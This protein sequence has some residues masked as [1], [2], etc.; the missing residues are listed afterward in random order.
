MPAE[1]HP[2]NGFVALLKNR[3]FLCIWLAQVTSQIAQ[4]MINYLVI[5]LVEDLT[6]SS[7]QTGL[8]I[9]SFLIPGVFFA[10]V[11]G[12]VVD[13]CN[14]R[15]LLIV[16]TL[17][18]AVAAATYFI[19]VL[20]HKWPVAYL[21]LFIDVVT[22]LRN[23]VNQFFWPA[24]SSAIPQLVEREQF[25]TVN[26][27]IGTSTNINRVLGFVLLGPFLLK[28]VGIRI[29][30]WIIIGL[31]LVAAAFLWLIPR[32]ACASVNHNNGLGLRRGQ[33]IL[34][35]AIQ[36]LRT[37]R[38]ELRESWALI[39]R[40]RPMTV[41]IAYSS[42]A[43]ALSL[44]I[45]T[46]APGFVTR[47]LGLGSE[48]SVV[49]ILPAGLGMMAGLF[50]VGILSRWLGRQRLVDRSML[51]TGLILLALASIPVLQKYTN[52]PP[53]AALDLGHPIILV[54][55]TLCFL[56]GMVDS[57]IF[58][59]TQ[60]LLQDRA[61]EEAYGRVFANRQLI[62]NVA[63]MGP[64]LLTGAMGDLVGIPRVLA[65]VGGIT[66]TI[67]ILGILYLRP[68]KQRVEEHETP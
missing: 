33:R 15:T 7:T 1:S 42:V 62:Q 27:L 18:R 67:A 16:T 31:Y 10:S 54:S 52:L 29:V 68:P 4:N 17:L 6:G 22:F 14:R 65:V 46:L 24:E 47:V 58:V 5:V 49:V 45:G 11:A 57:I 25:F 50:L 28:L 39:L 3:N 37:M 63:S 44:M 23:C 43:F 59:P 55:V 19:Y 51:L 13:R 9:L 20:Q 26:A 64:I 60:T 40:D 61:P 32:A 36:A 35:Q 8:A 38:Q 48:D 2:Q 53:L 21:V 66:L 41:A 34:P 12:I 56:L 30:L